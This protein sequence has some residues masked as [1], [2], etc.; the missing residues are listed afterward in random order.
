MKKAFTLAEVLITLGIIGIVAAMTLPSLIEK[1][2]KK[3]MVSRVKKIYTTV[4]Q[5]MLRSYSEN[6]EFSEWDLGTE[7][8]K[9]NLK[10]VVNRYFV[11]YFKILRTVDIESCTNSYQCY[12]FLLADGT[13][14]LFSLD[15]NSNKGESPSSV[16]INADFKGR[17][18]DKKLGTANN[19]DFSRHNFYLQLSKGRNMKGKVNFF[20]WGTFTREGLINNATYGC[21]ANIPKDR[22]FNCGA[23]I[24]YDGWEIK[25]DYPW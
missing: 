2:Q 23:L 18:S 5:A 13:T 16:N 9:D 8:T 3:V 7:Y 12:G 11:P 17:G 10:R 6:G 14:L 22:R 4:S 15:G 20:Y 19:R 25:D 24:Q 21:N 1:H